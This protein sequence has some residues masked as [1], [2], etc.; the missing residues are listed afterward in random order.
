MD[1][2]EEGK[3]SF[4]WGMQGAVKGYPHQDKTGD[5]QILHSFLT[6]LSPVPIT[7]GS[8]VLSFPSPPIPP[9]AILVVCFPVLL[10]WVGQSVTEGL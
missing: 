3:L 6:S 9:A 1:P 10:F 5:I 4:H 8:E 7:Q 2:D